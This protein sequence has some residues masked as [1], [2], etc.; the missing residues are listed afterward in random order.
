MSSA[1]SY[2]MILLSDKTAW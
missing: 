1:V 2:E